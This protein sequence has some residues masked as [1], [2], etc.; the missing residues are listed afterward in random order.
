MTPR[1]EKGQGHVIVVPLLLVFCLL[2]HSA[3]AQSPALEKVQ[4]ITLKGKAGKLDHLIVNSKK[5]DRLFQANKV[6]NT[7][8]I[9]DLKGGKL[10]KQITGQAGVQGL[11]YAAD[12]DRLYVALGTGGY[13]NIFDANDYKLLKTIKFTD[14]ADNVRYNA[15]THLV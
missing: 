11:A 2:S 12:L 10:V 6:N 1:M 5:P 14:D 15:R 8:D 3:E 9:V 4:T 7:L 13:C